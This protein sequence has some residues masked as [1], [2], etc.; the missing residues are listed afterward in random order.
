M[1]LMFSPLFQNKSLLLKVFSFLNSLITLL[2][3]SKR[4]LFAKIKTA[5][6][7]YQSASRYYESASRYYESASHYYESACRYYESA[8]HYYLSACVLRADSWL[9]FN[10]SIF[11]CRFSPIAESSDLLHIPHN[12][13]PT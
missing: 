9:D 10:N 1:P 3:T 12:L 11:C 2:F 7:L 8:S 5:S 6:A 4:S 13:L